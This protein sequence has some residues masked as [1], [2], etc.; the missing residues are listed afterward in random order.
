[1]VHEVHQQIHA[2]LQLVDAHV[3]H[4]YLLDR[5][6]AQG[7]DRRSARHAIDDGAADPAL[8]QDPPLGAPVDGTLHQRHKDE[9]WQKKH[10]PEKRQPRLQKEHVA[11]DTD[12][13]SALQQRLR[14]GE[15]GEAADRLG[16]LDDH[17]DLHAGIRRGLR[18]VRTAGDL[19]AHAQAQMAHRA[20]RD[21]AA[22]DVQC[23]LQA[24]LGE[25]DQGIAARQ[26]EQ[27]LERTIFDDT[28]DD[29]ALQFQR[30]RTQREH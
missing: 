29:A 14:K 15:A 6:C 9:L 21:P 11:D 24:L 28:V 27:R 5:L 8:D 3:Q 23:K 26:P 30:Y 18:A 1:M 25:S 10:E 22:I 13:D 19:V 12:Q 4:E 2:E 17:G 16:L 20:F 7:P